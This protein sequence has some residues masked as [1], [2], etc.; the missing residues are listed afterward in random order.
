MP[1]SWPRPLRPS[2]SRWHASRSAGR[3][4]TRAEKHCREGLRLDPENASAL[5]LL[6]AVFLKTGRRRQAIT[7][8]AQASRLNPIDSA[9]RKNAIRFA[10]PSTVGAAILLYML[11]AADI[12]GSFGIAGLVAGIVAVEAVF[13]RLHPGP[14]WRV[15]HWR[16]PADGVVPASRKLR[17]ELVKSRQPGDHPAYRPWWMGP[18][19]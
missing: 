8:F 17:H 15:I 10:G 16:R 3:S 1:A 2:T 19:Q 9:P 14:L 7:L 12:G 11:V 18:R 5:N 4:G 13:Y 6:G